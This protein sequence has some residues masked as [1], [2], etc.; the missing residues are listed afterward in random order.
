[1]DAIANGFCITKIAV[2]NAP[3]PVINPQT[4]LSVSQAIELIAKSIRFEDA[5]YLSFI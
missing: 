5:H 3:D 2:A 4:G 1:L